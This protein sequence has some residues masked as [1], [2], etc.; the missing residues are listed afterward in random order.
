MLILNSTKHAKLTIKKIFCFRGM[1]ILSATKPKA[2]A[3]AMFPI[4]E[5]LEDFRGMIICEYFK[6]QIHTK[7]YEVSSESSFSDLK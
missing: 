2:M 1:L 4:L 3:R 6:T 5:D 7:F